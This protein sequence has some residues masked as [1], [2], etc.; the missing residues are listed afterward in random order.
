MTNANMLKTLEQTNTLQTRQSNRTVAADKPLQSIK[1]MAAQD[2]PRE[3][4]LARGQANLNNAELLQVVIGSGI[5]GA[6]VTQIASEILELL[7]EYHCKPPLKRLL[8]VRGVSTATA[9]KL[10][11]SLELTGRLNYTGKLIQTEDDILPLLAD[12]R[13]KK[14]EHFIVITLDGAN[15]LIEKRTI[16]IGT[17]NASL[18]HPREVF[19]DAITDRA[20]GI[21]VAHNHPGGSLEPSGADIVTTRRLTAAGEL[22]GIKMLDHIIVTASSHCI[23]EV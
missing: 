21:V 8:A 6:D 12:I 7:E 2:R 20:A 3:K 9:T 13:F 18:V 11:A 4:M 5:R 10:L 19:A 16:T 1:L 22:L 17:L 15:R 23:V 14:Q